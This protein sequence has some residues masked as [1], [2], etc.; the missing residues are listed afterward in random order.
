MPT[1]GAGGYVVEGKSQKGTEALD[2]LLLEVVGNAVGIVVVATS[3]QADNGE[4]VAGTP[5]G[6]SEFVLARPARER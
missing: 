6:R 5:A 4:G 1:W 2:K 3:G